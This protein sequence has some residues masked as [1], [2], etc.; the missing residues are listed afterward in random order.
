VRPGADL[1]FMTS[2]NGQDLDGRIG[3]GPEIEVL[4]NGFGVKEKK[5]GKHGRIVSDRHGHPLYFFL[6][7]LLSFGKLFLFFGQN[8][9]LFLAK[10]LYVNKTSLFLSK[11]FILGKTFMFPN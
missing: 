5:K 3:S 7:K 2:T 10:P 9:Y 4:G 1:G 11:T 6:A 8:V